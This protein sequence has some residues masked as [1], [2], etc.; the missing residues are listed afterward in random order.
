MITFAVT[1]PQSRSIPDLPA[2]TSPI[3][4]NPYPQIKINT[5]PPHPDLHQGAAMITFAIITLAIAEAG[6]PVCDFCTGYVMGTEIADGLYAV[7]I[8]HDPDCIVELP[9]YEKPS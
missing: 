5:P 1:I 2:E 3:K 6:I 4:I 7:E 9:R 8:H